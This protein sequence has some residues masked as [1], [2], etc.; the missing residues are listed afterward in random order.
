MVVRSNDYLK[1]ARN[2]ASCL[3]DDSFLFI[4][5]P[6]VHVNVVMLEELFKSGAERNV[7]RTKYRRQLLYQNTSIAAFSGKLIKLS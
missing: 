2:I 5:Q 4:L 3:V 6:H 1:G 7:S